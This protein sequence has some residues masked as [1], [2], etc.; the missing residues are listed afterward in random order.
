MFKA[1]RYTRL[2]QAFNPWQWISN[3][4]TGGVD[5]SFT[6]Q[7]IDTFC[8]MFPHRAVLQNNSI[9]VP[10]LSPLYQ[11]MYDHMRSSGHP[12]RFQTA[13]K[14]RVGSFAK[15]LDWA[16]TYGAHAVELS[17]GFQD[18]SVAPCLTNNQLAHYDAEL[19]AK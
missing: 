3:A 18:C 14:P 1:F 9:R 7:M 15:T 13:T 16:L 8:E 19:R 17:P 5:L 2:A 6:L 12:V 11:Q 10:V 4:G